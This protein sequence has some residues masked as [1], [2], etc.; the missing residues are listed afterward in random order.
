MEAKYPMYCTWPEANGGRSMASSVPMGCI[1]PQKVDSP[2][3]LVH[4]EMINSEDQVYL[5]VIVVSKHC[6]VYL[7]FDKST[8]LIC[9]H[10]PT[11]CNY[12]WQ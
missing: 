4:S 3:A 2:M 9:A 8:D 1:T 7:K 5:I 10:T 12:G 11:H 6:I